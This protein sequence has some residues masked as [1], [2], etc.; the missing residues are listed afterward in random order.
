LLL[1]N[2]QSTSDTNNLGRIK[3]MKI[4]EKNGYKKKENAGKTEV[5]KK[6]LPSNSRCLEARHMLPTGFISSWIELIG[7]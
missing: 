2:N 4:K 3:G 6:L 7:Q 1:D 5:V